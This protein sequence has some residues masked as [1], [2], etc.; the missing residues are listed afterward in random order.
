MASWLV[1]EIVWPAVCDPS[2]L[3]TTEAASQILCSALGPSIKEGHLG[4]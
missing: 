1:D 2:G 3:V 4:V